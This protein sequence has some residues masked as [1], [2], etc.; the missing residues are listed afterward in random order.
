MKMIEASLEISNKAVQKD[1]H[2]G[3][4]VDNCVL[5]VTSLCICQFEQKVM[6]PS[7]PII[8]GNI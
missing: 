7:D 2:N 4:D 3:K 8:N 6:V 1:A 5:V